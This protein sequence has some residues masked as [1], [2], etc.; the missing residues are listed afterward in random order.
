MEGA[1]E[2]RER[3]GREEGITIRV[4]KFLGGSWTCKEVFFCKFA[5]EL[6]VPVS[7]EIDR[8]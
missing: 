3:E 4:M 8:Q 5:T 1:G 2:T 6:S 7:A